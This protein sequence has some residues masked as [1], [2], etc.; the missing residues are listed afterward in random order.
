MQH[1]VDNRYRVVWKLAGEGLAEVYLARDD[2]LGR[3][4]VLKVLGG[5]HADDV[6]SVEFFRNEARRAAA[7][8]HPSIV[9]VF[10]QGETEDG[11]YYIAMEYLPGGNLKERLAKLEPLPVRRAAAVALQISR[12]LRAAH[13]S[14][15]VHGGL[16]P[17][18]VLITESGDVKV[19]D[20]G[21]ARAELSTE[22]ET[23]TN[24]PGDPY[25]APEQA[26]GEEATRESDL[27]S[28]GVV[29]YEML[30]GGLPRDAGT[31]GEIEKT[32]SGGVNAIVTTLLSKNPDD[33]YADADKLIEDLERVEAGLEP[34]NVGSPKS[35][36]AATYESGVPRRVERRRNRSG[37][38]AFLLV[39]PIFAILLMA[40][41]AWAG[42][43]L[44][45]TSTQDQQPEPRPEPRPEPQ[46]V[47][48]RVPDLGGMTLEAARQQVGDDFEIARDGQENSSQ[49]E[50]TILE[51]EPSG[52]ESEKGSEILAV[53]ASGQ[54]EVPAVEGGTLDEA[55]KNLS[56]AGFEPAVTEVESAA[57]GEGL[58]LSQDPASGE[59]IGV[60]SKVEIV[61]GTGPAPV[62]APPP[63][64]VPT[65]AEVIPPEPVEVPPPVAAPPPAEV[66]PPEP[67]EAPPPV[68]VPGLYGYTPGQAAARL[69]NL[70]L[71]LG[72]RDTAPSDE[73]AKG[74][75]I[76]Q[77][78]APGAGV[79]PGTV[80]GVTISSGP[81]MSPVPNVV[82]QSLGQARQNVAG[83][84]FSPNA[85]EIP[86]A[87]W[88][89]GT[90]LYTDP[91]TGARILPGSTVTIGY[92]S[93]PS[94][95]QP[96]AG[97]QNNQQNQR[98]R[99]RPASS[100]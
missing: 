78:M 47:M 98:V 13:D 33:R 14:G 5:S 70:G 79:E 82:G 6:E 9:S 72:G 19:K 81:E 61:V 37:R 21:I 59:T 87:Q 48:L 3:D 88:P 58:I 35:N 17:N 11:T 75:I 44:L 50:G 97:G 55:R 29:L 26:A 64:E 56:D 76:A 89:R 20:F 36:Q 42:F 67:V 2:I 65:P 63:V 99:N 77:S 52:G 22:P 92:S 93:G 10:D 86:N 68:E 1:L 69:R 53:V 8:S 71:V 34:V 7:L 12:A 24:R 91:G 66:P 38:G 74:G 51:Y 27:Y 28:L 85:L 23:T 49:P 57:D 43:G 45:Q 60:G 40:G 62:E 80:V 15:V 32:V 94:T 83:A 100:P 18:N 54:N 46:P 84:G 25:L 30:N 31:T 90:V 16:K 73:V 96:A 4:I 39:V 95:R 41:L